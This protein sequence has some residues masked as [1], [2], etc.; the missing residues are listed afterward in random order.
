MR[1]IVI[2]SVSE[3]SFVLRGAKDLDSS[4]RSE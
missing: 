2:L 3:G 1:K 4:P